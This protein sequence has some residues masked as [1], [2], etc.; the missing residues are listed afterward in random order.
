MAQVDFQ[1]GDHP[2]VWDG[3]ND[4]GIAAPAGIYFLCVRQGTVMDSRRFVVTR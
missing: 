2:I 3:A 4:R 1:P